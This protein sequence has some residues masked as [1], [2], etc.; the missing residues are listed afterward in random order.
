MILTFGGQ[1][2]GAGNDTWIVMERVISGDGSQ[3]LM[4]R[5]RLAE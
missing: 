5:P 3:L 1:T 4:S 2:K